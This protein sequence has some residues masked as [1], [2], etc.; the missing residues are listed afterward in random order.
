M[1]KGKKGKKKKKKGQARG[2]GIILKYNEWVDNFFE[3]FY[4]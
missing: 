1:I 3:S 4:Y 2:E